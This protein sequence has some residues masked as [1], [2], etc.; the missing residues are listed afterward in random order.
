V[1]DYSAAIQ[2]A[3]KEG[4]NSFHN[5]FNSAADV[6]ESIIKGHWDMSTHI[7]TP[8]VEQGLR[9][10]QRLTALEIGYGGGRLLNAA[11]SFFH[12]AIGVD[13]HSEQQAAEEFLN[14]QGKSNF[15][16]HTCD[17]ISLPV[18]SESIDFV[19]SFIVLQHLP[20]F[21][22]FE[23][24]WRETHRVLRPGGVAQ[25]YFGSWRKLNRKVRWANH[26]QGHFEVPDP[27]PNHTTLV[28]RVGFA[29]ALARRLGFSV[30][31]SGPSRRYA[32]HGACNSKGG[33]DYLTLLKPVA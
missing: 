11:C 1:E 24:Y 30:V 13:I 6:R 12:H 3:R 32:I 26:R 15:T 7:L 9:F 8:A 21:S 2:S 27:Q 31:D 18:E 17:G 28:L 22:T 16:L 25:L 20:R 14:S 5:W 23:S 19:Y 4:E 33:Q 10:P 29:K